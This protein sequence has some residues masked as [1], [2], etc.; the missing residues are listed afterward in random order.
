[1]SSF[2]EFFQKIRQPNQY[3]S[4]SIVLGQHLYFSIQAA[5]AM[6]IRLVLEA[7]QMA[8]SS[9]EF[10][11][12]EEGF[13]RRAYLVAVSL[14]SAKP[15][16]NQTVR[17]NY[18]SIPWAFPR[19]E[20]GYSEYVKWWTTSEGISFWSR[21]LPD[22]MVVKVGIPRCP[23]CGR[24]LKDDGS[25]PIHGDVNGSEISTVRY[26]VLGEEWERF[27][28]ITKYLDPAGY[29]TLVSRF[30]THAMPKA[31]KISS[32]IARSVDA[33]LYLSGI[34]AVKETVIE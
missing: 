3:G 9:V 14:V 6:K 13:I 23:F 2:D 5:P 11:E 20:K 34:E 18:Y 12:E 17:G 24:I 28:L 30:A 27:F 1:M 25:C 33:S 16:L 15:E 21:L 22:E 29:S 31:M 10:D 4:Y 8:R 32:K 26:E 19:N 7:A